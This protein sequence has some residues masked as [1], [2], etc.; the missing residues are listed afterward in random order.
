MKA[1][2]QSQLITLVPSETLSFKLGKNV[3]A[4][5]ILRV[6]NSSDNK[7]AFKVKT[8]QPSWYY[9]RPNQQILNPGVISLS[10]FDLF[11]ILALILLFEI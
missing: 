5:E 1:S 11:L 6:T 7:V 9:V 10:Y 2:E 3:E 8:T 4:K